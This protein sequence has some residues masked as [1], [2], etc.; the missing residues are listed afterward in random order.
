MTCRCKPQLSVISVDAATAGTVTLTVD[1]S[2]DA[3]GVNAPFRLCISAAMIPA[4]NTGQIVLTDGTTALEAHL[5]CTGNYL[6]ADSLKKFLCR[7]AGGCCPA[8]DFNVYRGNDPAQATFQHRLCPSA[9]APTAGG[10]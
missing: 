4:A 9:F 10:G 3:V 1:K 5:A 8:F 6:R 7:N 2:F